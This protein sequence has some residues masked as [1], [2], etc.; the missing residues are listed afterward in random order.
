MNARKLSDA[1]G[2]QTFVLVFGTGD[3][4]TKGLLDFGRTPAIER[5]ERMC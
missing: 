5:R 2:V 4:A 3:E 1:G